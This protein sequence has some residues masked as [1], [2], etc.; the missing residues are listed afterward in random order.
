MLAHVKSRTPRTT[1]RWYDDAAYEVYVHWE[2]VP[3]YDHR[4][5]DDL[6]WALALDD[7]RP[8]GLTIKN[9]QRLLGPSSPHPASRKPL[10][11]GLAC[12]PAAAIGFGVGV[13]IKMVVAG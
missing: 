7:D 6:T 2:N 8:V 1:G 10:P 3:S 12:I 4:V 13:L 5:D 11:W 9:V